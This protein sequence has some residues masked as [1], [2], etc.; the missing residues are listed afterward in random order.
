MF[1]APNSC[2]RKKERLRPM[3]SAAPLKETEEQSRQGREIKKIRVEFDELEIRNIMATQ[4]KPKAGSLRIN[5]I[6]KLI[7]IDLGH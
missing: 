6:D 5:Q 2:V 7:T 3:T 1:I 4:I